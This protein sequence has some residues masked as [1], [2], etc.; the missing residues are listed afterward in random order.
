MINK[1]PKRH[2]PVHGK[3]SDLPPGNIHSS[4]CVWHRETFVYWDGVCDAVSGIQD[5]TGGATRR[6]QG[7][8]GLNR[9]E[10]SWY[11]ECLKKDLCGTL[12]MLT[13]VQWCLGQEHR[14]LQRR[15]GAGIE[16]IW[17]NL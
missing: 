12:A 4:N 1:S 14:M 8:N 15:M 5:D 9:H 17:Q 10:K 11:I 16:G 13:W 7:Q 3:Q 6:V 2:R